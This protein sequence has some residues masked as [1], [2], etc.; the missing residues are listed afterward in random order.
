[1]RLY[2]RSADLRNAGGERHGTVGAVS[3]AAG[4]LPRRTHCIRL[5]ATT[6]WERWN[7]VLDD[8]SISS[9]SMN[10]L[11][12]YSYGSVIHYVVRDI[13]GIKPLAPGYSRVRIDPRPSREI[14]RGEVFVPFGAGRIPGGMGGKEDGSVDLK[15]LVPFDCEAWVQL[16]DRELVLAAG[17]TKVNYRPAIS[18]ACTIGKRS[19]RPA[20]KTIGRW[21]C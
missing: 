2:G 8:G 13:V 14:R 16:P 18:A 3:A 20:G 10:S 11:N 9:T 15:V 7:S 1:M 4:W 17:E 12:H 6:I 5:G 21:R 19:L